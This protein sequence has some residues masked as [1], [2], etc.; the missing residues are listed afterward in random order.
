L[1]QA[2]AGVQ[3]QPDPDG[4]S[5]TP[6]IPD[7]RS[8]PLLLFPD[9]LN[10]AGLLLVLHRNTS[11]LTELRPTAHSA[12]PCGAAGQDTIVS[13]SLC[14]H[15]QNRELRP[16]QSAHMAEDLGPQW[17]VHVAEDAQLVEGERRL[18]PAQRKVAPHL[19]PDARIFACFAASVDARLFVSCEP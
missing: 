8:A 13:C 15:L 11:C 2:K 16:H 19:A 10:E 18:P 14:P 3:S 7:T 17:L 12:Q 9:R 5:S 1:A 6:A 4:M